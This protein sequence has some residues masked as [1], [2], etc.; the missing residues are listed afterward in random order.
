[1]EESAQA[2]YEERVYSD[3]KEIREKVTKV[4]DLIESQLSDTVHSFLEGDIKLANDVVLGDRRVNRKIRE[5]D[6]M[7]HSFIVRH[8]PTA[9]P[10]RYV[11]A[12]LRLDVALER[13]GD[14]ASTIG[15]EIIQLKGRPPERIMRDVEL[16]SHQARRTLSQA[17][18]AFQENDAELAQETYG[19]A[20]HTDSTLEK[21]FEELLTAGKSSEMSLRDVFA[22]LR[23]INL[24][25]R[26]DDQAENVCEQT[27]FAVSGEIKD[28][29]SFRILFLDEQ[30]SGLSQM[31]EAYASRAFPESGTYASAG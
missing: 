26:V 9:G 21:V 24:L 1:M 17:L 12:V 20:G 13:V 27:L 19:A 7:C 25:K 30:N 4:A 14:Y 8:A 3:L 29:K 28:P 6:R 18:L 11:S 15:R 2:R 31:A 22:L 10:L 23:I 16:I 5:I